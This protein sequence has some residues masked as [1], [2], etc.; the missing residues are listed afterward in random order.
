MAGSVESPDGV[1]SYALM[2]Q[3]RD[4]LFVPKKN[5]YAAMQS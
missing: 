3:L 1:W 4:K 2:D 5:P